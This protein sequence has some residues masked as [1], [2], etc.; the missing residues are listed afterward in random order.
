MVSL[1]CSKNSSNIVS[2]YNCVSLQIAL[3]KSSRINLFS[4]RTSQFLSS[5]LYP[6]KGRYDSK[7]FEGKGR[8]LILGK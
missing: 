1:G 3:K 2:L 7:D 8:L 5:Y 6:I 4:K